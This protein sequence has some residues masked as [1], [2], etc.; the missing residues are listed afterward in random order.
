VYQAITVTWNVDY[1][2]IQFGFYS[3]ICIGVLIYTLYIILIQ[4]GLK[5]AIYETNYIFHIVG[6]N[7]IQT[8][9]I[10]NYNLGNHHSIE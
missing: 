10:I 9:I 3:C 1:S 7:R 6:C 8:Q 5:I 4:S 2:I